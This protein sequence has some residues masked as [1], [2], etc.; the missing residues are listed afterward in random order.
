ML[1]HKLHD[2]AVEGVICLLREYSHA[3]N[4]PLAAGLACRYLWSA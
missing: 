1:E 4:F 2:R 3:E